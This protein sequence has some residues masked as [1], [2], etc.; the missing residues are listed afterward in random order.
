[1]G[2][3]RE[4]KFRVWDKKRKVMIQLTNATVDIDGQ[5]I[6]VFEMVN[7]IPDNI[8]LF[9]YLRTLIARGKS[10]VEDLE[11]MQFTGLLDKNGREIYEGDILK[12]NSGIGK[13]VWLELD[14]MWAVEKSED[15]TYPFSCNVYSDNHEVIGNI[16]ENSELLDKVTN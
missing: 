4:I 8:Q 3:M 10:N 15:W 1:V 11:L 12:A 9:D 7:S 13:V 2:M 16:Y 14:A 6:A 5:E